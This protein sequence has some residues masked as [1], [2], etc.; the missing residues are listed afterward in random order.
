MD[1][2]EKQ[3]LIKKLKKGEH[4]DVAKEDNDLEKSVSYMKKP[5][6]AKAKYKD[7]YDDVKLSIKEDW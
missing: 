5:A 6:A 3:Q 4:G 7:F 2:K 1:E